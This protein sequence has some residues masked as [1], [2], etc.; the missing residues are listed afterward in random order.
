MFENPDIGFKIEILVGLKVAGTPPTISD[1]IN[2]SYDNVH[3][4]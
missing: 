3:L 4:K 1:R 2:R